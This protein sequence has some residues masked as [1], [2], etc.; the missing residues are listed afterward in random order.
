RCPVTRNPLSGADYRSEELAIGVSAVVAAMTAG[1]CATWAR[2][3][4]QVRKEAALSGCRG[5]RRRARPEPEA[6]DT[7][8]DLVS[9]D[10][11]TVHMSSVDQALLHLVDG[12]APGRDREGDE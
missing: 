3:S 12:D 9:E 4:G 1:S 6:A 10:G 8:G 5:C 2:E 11:C 7:P